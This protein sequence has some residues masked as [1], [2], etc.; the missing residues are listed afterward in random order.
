MMTLLCSLAPMLCP[1][2]TLALALPVSRDLPLTQP[3]A[4]TAPTSLINQFSVNSAPSN[5]AQ[6][7]TPE[8][9]AL[10]SKLGNVIKDLNPNSFHW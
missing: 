6:L 3:A 5:M 8:A 4:P 10:I 2:P 7:N 9:I 1:R